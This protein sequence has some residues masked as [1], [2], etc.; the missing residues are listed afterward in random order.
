MHERKPLEISRFEGTIVRGGGCQQAVESFKRKIPEG[1]H[2]SEFE[3]RFAH[4]QTKMEIWDT[5]VRKHDL[6]QEAI[7]VHQGLEMVDRRDGH[8]RNQQHLANLAQQGDQLVELDSMGVNGG[9]FSGVLAGRVK[10]SMHHIRG[11]DH[12]H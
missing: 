4:V 6:E 7:R 11:I 12:R 5:V 10:H 2:G 3:A 1:I 9:F 8:G